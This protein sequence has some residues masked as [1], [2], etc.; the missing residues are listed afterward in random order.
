MKYSFVITGWKEPLTVAQTI[1]NILDSSKNNLLSDLEIILASP[2]DETR[3]AAKAVVSEFKYKY[4]SYI[5]DPQKG[6]PHALNLVLEKAKGEILIYTDGDV[7]IGADC[8]P[9]LIKYFEDPEVG[10]VTGRP[11][12]ADPKDNALGYWGNL[13]AEVAHHKRQKIFSSGGFYFLSGYLYATRNF[14]DLRFPEDIL[15]DDAWMTVQVVKRG[16]KLK[17]A[18][19]A[20]VFIKYPKN[21]KDWIKQKKRSLGGYHQLKSLESSVF[22]ANGVLSSQNR[23]LTNELKYALFPFRYAKN[24]KQL[25]YSILLFPARLYLW[26]VIFYERKIQKKTFEQTWQRVES[27]K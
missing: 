25:W 12:S 2:D 26:L 15:V 3:D 16:L 10:G 19:D 14:K 9:H 17:Y 4:F 13:L 5:K 1:R 27:T 21:F 7:V 23:K 18:P 11:V 6:K 22:N 20:K 24:L 8:L